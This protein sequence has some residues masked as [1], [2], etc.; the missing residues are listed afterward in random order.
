MM[1]LFVNLKIYQ[2]IKRF[3]S[4]LNLIIKLELLKGINQILVL[5]EIKIPTL[6]A[7][8]TLGTF[9]TNTFVDL[10]SVKKIYCRSQHKCK[11]NMHLIFTRKNQIRH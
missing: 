6:T 2:K 9:C 7:N 11:L 8:Y 10:F 4:L 5:Y 3:K 1:L